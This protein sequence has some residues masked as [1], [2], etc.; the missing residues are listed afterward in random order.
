[1]PDT[2]TTAT[3]RTQA[4]AIRR[5]YFLDQWQDDRAEYLAIERAALDYLSALQMRRDSTYAADAVKRID[6]HAADFAGR[7]LDLIA[8]MHGEA[9]RAADE[10][11]ID[12]DSITYD[13][14]ILRGEYET[15]DKRAEAR[16]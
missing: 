15:W 9:K 8:D 5:R 12:P 11:G 3:Q 6:N 1:M 14:G 4:S 13:D 10:E 2:F 7:T 16:R